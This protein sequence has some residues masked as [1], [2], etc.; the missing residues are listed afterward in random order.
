VTG[1]RRYSFEVALLGLALLAAGCS[2]SS[3]KASNGGSP[4]DTGTATAGS[5]S[6]SPTTTTAKKKRNVIAW[7]LSLGPGAP[8]GPPEFTAYREL[9]QLKCGKV[10][11]RVAE[12]QEPAQTLYT[13]AARACLAALDGRA[14]LWPRADAAYEAV[15]DHRGELT[16]MDRAAF[17]LLE[18]LVTLHKQFPHRGF[19]SA[20]T[21]Q[22]K[23]PPC[24]SI[25]GLTPDHGPAGTVVRMVGRHLGESV[26]GVDVVDSFGTALPA[27]NVSHVK[28]AL[29]FTMP[30]APP[31]G[32]SAMACIVVRAAPDWSAAGA[33]FTY[34][35]ADVGSPTTF[36]CP[37][38][39][40][41]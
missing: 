1:A 2:G 13:G 26:V 6:P 25:V 7:V 34:E 18:R 36:D 5:A 37:S 24:P 11:D 15:A 28:G 16:C 20:P 39:K 23:A 22:A 35:S 30:E 33:M 29:E 38:A 19:E 21:D 14:D 17:A 10:F 3:E 27:E 32:A 4:T 12:L 41:G 8:D 31:A 40:A 9:Q